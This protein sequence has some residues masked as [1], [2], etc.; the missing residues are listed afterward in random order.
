VVAAQAGIVRLYAT[1]TYA[2]VVRAGAL[3]AFMEAEDV[4]VGSRGDILADLK[5]HVAPGDW[6]LVKG[7]RAA[8]ME[9]I[10]SGVVAWAGGKKTEG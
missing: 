8:E 3:E 9:T 5:Q 4:V 1:G 10:V 6:V 7:S 2:D